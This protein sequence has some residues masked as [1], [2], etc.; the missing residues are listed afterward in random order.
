MSELTTM[1]ELTTIP[2]VDTIAGLIKDLV[3]YVARQ[4][5]YLID[6]AGLDTLGID[7]L[8]ILAG[9]QRCFGVQVPPS[10]IRTDIRTVGQLCQV[11][12][13]FVHGALR[14]RRPE[15]RPSAPRTGARL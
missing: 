11:L 13:T 14:T 10:E 15:P 5:P 6:D 4:S 3:A 9:I 12:G 2:D 1:P 8:F 7:R